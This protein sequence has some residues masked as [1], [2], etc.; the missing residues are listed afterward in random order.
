MEGS[1]EVNRFAS[2]PK[3]KR[4]INFRAQRNQTAREQRWRKSIARPSWPVKSSLFP[5]NYSL[6]SRAA[7]SIFKY[8]RPRARESN[9]CFPFP[10]SD[11]VTHPIEAL[12]HSLQPW[13]VLLLASPRPTFRFV[14]DKNNYYER[15]RQ[16]R[17]SDRWPLTLRFIT[18]DKLLMR[19][20]NTIYERC[21][22][23]RS[24][25]VRGIRRN[26]VQL[27]AIEHKLAYT[28]CDRC[29]PDRY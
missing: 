4:A 26:I 9:R 10:S 15:P 28:P 6:F 21:W 5:T 2:T 19:L 8:S 24:L 25:S 14:F 27:S 11:N 13:W 1:A 17:D 20:T 12:K 29:L 18:M 7:T 16:H 3:I 22:P 23:L